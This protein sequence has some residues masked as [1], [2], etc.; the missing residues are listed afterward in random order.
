M[1]SVCQYCGGKIIVP[2]V[3]VH[4]S[5][6]EDEQANNNLITLQREQRLYEVQNSLNAGRKIEAISMFREYF[7]TDLAT[8]KTAVEKLEAGDRMAV[9]KVKVIA[10]ERRIEERIHGGLQGNKTAAKGASFIFWLVV[11]LGFLI[12][13]YI[14]QGS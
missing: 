8:A 9:Q 7:G 1:F 3:I 13:T 12:A 10:P 2:S 14:F 11:I 5:E 4:Q 6:V